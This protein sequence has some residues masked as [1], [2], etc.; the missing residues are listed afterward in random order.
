MGYDGDIVSICAFMHKTSGFMH[1]TVLW[2]LLDTASE[3][4][5]RMGWLVRLYITGVRGVTAEN[6]YHVL[7]RHHRALQR[8][9]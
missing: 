4:G 5:K 9:L 1:K 7:Q 2:L 3:L 6:G 8:H